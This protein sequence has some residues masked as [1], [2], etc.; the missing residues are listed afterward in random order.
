[1]FCVFL[2]ILLFFDSMANFF[3]LVLAFSFVKRMKG[4]YII[5]KDVVI[6]V[7]E[8]FM[9]Q[10]IFFLRGMFFFKYFNWWFCFLLHFKQKTKKLFFNAFDHCYIMLQTIIFYVFFIILIFKLSKFQE[11]ITILSLFFSWGN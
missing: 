3:I 5:T 11:W 10:L 6:V 1:M 7:K 4:N 2:E 8:M 9:L